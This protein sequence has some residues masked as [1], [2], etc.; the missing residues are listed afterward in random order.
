[1]DKE[2][3]EWLIKV[4][5]DRKTSLRGDA[6]KLVRKMSFVVAGNTKSFKMGEKTV[7]NR[8]LTLP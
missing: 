4:L 8:L 3:S 5:A 6:D 2:T 7:C 1:V